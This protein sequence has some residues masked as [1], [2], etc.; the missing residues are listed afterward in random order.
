MAKE[1]L[2]ELSIPEPSPEQETAAWFDYCALATQFSCTAFLSYTQ[3]HIGPLDLFFIDPL[4][5]A[6]Y[7]LGYD[8]FPEHKIVAELR[9]LTCLAG[10]TKAHVL[11]F[12][13]GYNASEVSEMRTAGPTN[14]YTAFLGGTL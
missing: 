12:H 7:L 13:G 4:Q 9:L 3:A 6:I 1:I 14:D 8:R 11:A 5:Q 2:N 10:L